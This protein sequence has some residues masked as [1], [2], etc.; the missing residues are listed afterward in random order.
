MVP[1]DIATSAK[2]AITY[3]ATACRIM[4]KNAN[5]IQATGFQFIEQNKTNADRFSVGVNICLL[6]SNFYP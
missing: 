5:K 3:E 4:P 2:T 6:R 1:S